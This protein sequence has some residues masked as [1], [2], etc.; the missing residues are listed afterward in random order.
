MKQLFKS[1][2]FVLLVLAGILPA[3]GQTFNSIATTSQTI[4]FTTSANYRTTVNAGQNT[5]SFSNL[6][7]DITYEMRVTSSGSFTNGANN[8]PVTNLRLTATHT[9]PTL[10]SNSSFANNASF[11]AN[12]Y[13]VIGNWAM[14]G[15]SNNYNG[16]INFSLS[17]PGANALVPGNTGF[18]RT[19][20]PVTLSF[21][22][23]SISGT[24]ATAIG[25]ARTM[26]VN[27]GIQNVI[28]VTLNTANTTL[29]INTPAHLRNGNS[30]SLPGQISVLSNQPYSLRAYATG[31]N[32]TNAA[33]QTFAV[34]NLSIRAGTAGIGANTIFQQLSSNLA[35]P[36]LLTTASP[37][38]ID[39]LIDVNYQINSGTGILRPSGTYTGNLVF[40]ATQ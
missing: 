38:A 28:E 30:L 29:N 8:I 32:L 23:F 13:L 26:T 11:P 35:A 12:G 24:S 27:V 17:Y 4:S 7:K 20:G 36:T 33:T 6:N 18:T 37:A 16:T 22:L 34:N 25:S 31:A 39:R 1:A 40:L 14:P 5:L 19:Y 21:A 10:S 9:F 15:G 3:S 2:A